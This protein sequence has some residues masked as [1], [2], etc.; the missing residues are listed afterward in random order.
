MRGLINEDQSLY[1]YNKC[2][3]IKSYHLTMYYFNGEP[4]I[5]DTRIHPKTFNHQQPLH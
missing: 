1:Q 2:K 5:D 3:N 4:T